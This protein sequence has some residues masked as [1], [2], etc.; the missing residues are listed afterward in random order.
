MSASEDAR[1]LVVDFKLEVLCYAAKSLPLMDAISK[2]VFPGLVDQL[3]S[4]TKAIM[5]YLLTQH[6]QVYESLQLCLYCQFAVYR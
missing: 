3:N 6:P 2:L 5:P 1:L 4:M